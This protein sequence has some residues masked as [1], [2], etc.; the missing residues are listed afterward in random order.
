MKCLRNI[1]T[2][3][4]ATMN[5]QYF[6]ISIKKQIFF[7]LCLFVSTSLLAIKPEKTYLMSPKSFGLIYKTLNV[8]T[9][10]GYNIHTWFIPAQDELSIKEFKELQ[11][12]GKIRKYELKD[13]LRRPTIIICDG[14][15]GN[16]G[17]QIPLAE[18]W[19]QKGFNVVLF[20]WRGFGDS[21]YFSINKDYLFYDEFLIDYLAV[22]DEVNKQPEVLND[23]IGLFGFSTG[24][25]FSFAAAYKNPK[26]KAV[27]LRGL[28][29]NFDDALINIVRHNP[30]FKDRFIIPEN[31]NKMLCPINIAGDF[32]KSSFLIVGAKDEITP[33]EMSRA[34]FSKLSCRKQLWI[35]DGA[36]HGGIDAPEIVERKTFIEKSSLFFLEN[37]KVV[38]DRVGE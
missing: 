15:S 27:V 4:N 18:Q 22:I 35:V 1:Q 38:D 5:N 29:T 9:S 25:Y 34:V 11:S 33:L 3:V 16:M 37:L 13:G 21:S 28:I 31:Y 17:Y 12:S 14:D 8:K 36:A 26:I 23:C 24:A 30:A 6:R 19:A 7:V 10:D 2:I 32:D 20:D